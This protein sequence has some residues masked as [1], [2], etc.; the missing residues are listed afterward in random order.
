MV[1]ISV[2]VPIGPLVLWQDQR[3]CT[4]ESVRVSPDRKRV[5]LEIPG[6]KVQQVV[7]I[8]T[9]NLLSQDNKTLW[10]PKTWY[11]LNAISPSEPF[12]VPTKITP[13]NNTTPQGLLRLQWKAGKVEIELPHGPKFNVD[14]VDFKAKHVIGWVGVQNRVEISTAA[15][16]GGIYFIRAI[17][18]GRILSR[19]VCF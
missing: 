10:Y 17:G 11:T 2:L 8:Q 14:M 19:R 6:L 16:P 9:Q 4:I 5:F 18:G 15:L 3:T 1:K 12:E 13:V 7:Y